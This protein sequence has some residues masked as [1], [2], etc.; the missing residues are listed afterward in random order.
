MGLDMNLY[1]RK[2]IEAYDFDKDEC[3]AKKITVNVKCEFADGEV[4]EE[5][6]VVDNPDFSGH[7]D[8]P[9]MYWRKANA[10]HRWIL[11]ATKQ[12]QDDC[13]SITVYGDTLLEL[14]KLCKE[15]LDDHTKAEKLL[16]TQAGFFFGSLEYDEYYFN[17]LQDTYNK[18]KD[19]NPEDCFIYRASW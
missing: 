19:V 14:A 13:R 1:K 3:L 2:H 4:K 7:I 18:L 6:Y 17:D 16:P 10:I 12:K 5:E 9:F 15:V 11:K 8:L